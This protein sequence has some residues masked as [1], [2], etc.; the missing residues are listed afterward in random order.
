MLVSV[1][2]T[3]AGANI[4]VY[5]PDLCY[6]LMSSGCCHLKVMPMLSMSTGCAAT[7]GHAE[8]G[9]PVQKSGGMLCQ[10]S[11]LLSL[12]QC[13]HIWAGGCLC[14]SYWYSWPI[15]FWRPFWCPWPVLLLRAMMVSMSFGSSENSIDVRDMCCPQRS[16][17][18]PWHMLM[19]ELCGPCCSQIQHESSLSMLLLLIKGKKAAFAVLSMAADAQLR[20]EDIEGF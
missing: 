16:S 15:L 2:H 6:H 10:W 5:G 13:R 11:V 14:D 18:G 9:R 7:P 17:R 8:F 1:V 3:T 19:L 20:K 4:W 12:R